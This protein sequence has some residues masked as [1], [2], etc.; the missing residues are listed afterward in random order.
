M[1]PPPQKKLKELVGEVKQRMTAIAADTGGAAVG[2]ERC[3]EALKQSSYSVESAVQY[4]KRQGSTSVKAASKSRCGAA[5]SA[6]TGD[7]AA[8]SREEEER[9]QRLQIV[10]P[11]T[12]RDV[13]AS[14]AADPWRAKQF[15]LRQL[16]HPCEAPG[17]YCKYPG[18]CPMQHLPRSLCIEHFFGRCVFGDACIRDHTVDGVDVRSHRDR[19][20]VLKED[21]RLFVV[22]ERI[23]GH[24]LQIAEEKVPSVREVAA[25]MDD[26]RLLK[27]PCEAPGRYC[28]YPGDCPM[29]HLPRSVC[30][31]YFFGRCV[32]G[33]D[34]IWDHT[35]DGMDVGS[36]RA[37]NERSRGRGDNKAHKPPATAPPSYDT[38]V[39]TLCAECYEDLK[40]KRYGDGAAR[41]RGN[42]TVQ[43]L[44][45]R[46]ALC[47]L[48]RR[49]LE[50]RTTPTLEGQVADS[51]T[52]TQTPHALPDEQ[53]GDLVSVDAVCDRVGPGIIPEA[54]LSV[55]EAV[56]AATVQRRSDSGS[57]LATYAE[58]ALTAAT[59][60]EVRLAAGGDEGV[61]PSTGTRKCAR[62][63]PVR[64]ST[65]HGNPSQ[66]PHPRPPRRSAPPPTPA[67]ETRVPEEE[68]PRSAPVLLSGD[69]ADGKVANLVELT[70]LQKRFPALEEPTVR[71]A[72]LLCDGQMEK[73]IENLQWCTAHAAVPAAPGAGG[74]AG[75]AGTETVVSTAII[76]TTVTHEEATAAYT[77]LKESICGCD[78]WR[79]L[80]DTAFKLRVQYLEEVERA[81]AAYTAGDGASAKK[82]A[83]KARS[84]IAEY[85]RRMRLAMVSLEVERLKIDR[86]GE[87]D[88]HYFHCNS[89]RD[90]VL[91]RVQLCRAQ[92]HLNL[93]VVYGIQTR[94]K[95]FHKS[96]KDAV[97]TALSEDEVL[98]RVAERR[99]IGKGFVDLRLKPADC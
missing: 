66:S 96:L 83:A 94:S 37:A 3:L 52:P 23:C 85:D 54:H 15:K 9:N 70:R 68:E 97:M 8:P 99:F 53:Q 92:S 76:D 38:F 1:P 7:V 89:V 33:D 17:R 90:A 16:K 75:T 12:A 91:R 50:S 31:S 63:T 35:V 79:T 2:K 43:V 45:A 65:S 26:L 6:P 86:K 40:A 67:L 11:S 73:A 93:R 72:Y 36:M 47:G 82:W 13:S 21:G 34:C 49:V 5:I 42:N 69:W 64:Y 27:H 84:N 20:E 30:T 80:R 57:V 77:R 59:E 87:L 81:M 61:V 71:I 4:L 18:D 22:T 44:D 25:M 14:F 74:A 19:P 10:I 48:C 39:S 98:Q 28:K 88:L 62:R 41:C 95:E 58:A 24:N 60:Q 51:A 29:Q 56:D 55:T 32:F 78:D 46:G